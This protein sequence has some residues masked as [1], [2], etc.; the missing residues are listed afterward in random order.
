MVQ[1]IDLTG[2]N[3]KRDPMPTFAAL[4][5]QGPVVETKIPF[6]GKISLVTTHSAVNA[7]LKDSDRFC[8]DASSSGRKYQLGVQWWMP[9][10]LKLLAESMLGK[11]DPDHRRLRNLV[12]QA[13]H[14]RSVDAYREGI[15]RIADRL[16]DQFQH[17]T[18]RDLVRHMARP[19]PLAVICELLGLPLEDQPKFIRWMSGISSISNIFGI[20]KIVPFINKLSDYLRDQF[21]D[22]RKNP[23][24]D[25][26]SGLVQAES[27]GQQLSENELLS[28]CFLLFVA[29]HE[30]TTHLISGSV[31]ALLQDRHVLSQ[32]END[33]SKIPGAVEELLRFVSPVQMTKPRFSIEDT[34]FFGSSIAKG[35]PLVALLASANCDPDV[36]D[37]PERLDIDRKKIHHL[38]FGTGA[39]FCLGL[40]L[41]R[42]E[43][44]IVLQKMFQRFPAMSLAVP[45]S[46]LRWTKRV[47][48]R[49]LTNLPLNLQ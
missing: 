3:F 20:F 10:S 5:A 43:A 46:N 6:L 8:V 14:R 37:H 34:D 28:M 38:A 36:F 21:E 48:I 26:I 47:G 24:D 16:I 9:K 19:L 11:D 7:L 29:G 30:T 42:L 13:F 27:E 25:L 1:K 15:E 22:R 45:E 41:A 49:A 17:S 39:H 23:R 40:Q 18:D 31:L 44:Q 32:L 12:D 35:T 2:L 4:R 33:W